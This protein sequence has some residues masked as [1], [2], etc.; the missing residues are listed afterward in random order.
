MRGKT[1]RRFSTDLKLGVVDAYLASE[2][3]INV[4]ATKAGIDHSMLH[5]WLKKYHAGELSLDLRR[6]E[7]LVETA[8]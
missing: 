6:E 1:Y 4:V 7:E 5:C 2:G 8:Q 3:S